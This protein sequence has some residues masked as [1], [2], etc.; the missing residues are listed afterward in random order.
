MGTM[1][2]ICVLVKY[3]PKRE[4][5]LESIAESIEGEFEESLRS[6]NQKL[7]KLCNKMDNSDKVFQ[8]SH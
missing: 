7:D 6:D 2:A 1:G 4:K 8:K 5:M 3:S